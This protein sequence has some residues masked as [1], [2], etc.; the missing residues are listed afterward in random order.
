MSI[1]TAGYRNNPM[2]D[3][4]VVPFAMEK[5]RD[6]NLSTPHFAKC[7]SPWIKY[8]TSNLH[9]ENIH[10]QST[11]HSVIFPIFPYYIF[12]HILSRPLT[13]YRSVYTVISINEILRPN[14]QA[15]A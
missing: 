14:T 12:G 13:T 5:H 2:D 11:V 8:S 9:C 10:L 4:R 3:L 6:S 7:Q 15:V 1:C